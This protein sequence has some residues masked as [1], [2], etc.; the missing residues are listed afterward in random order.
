MSAF[1]AKA[2]ITLCGNPLLQSL[3][4]Q[5]GHRFLRRKC[6]LLPKADIIHSIVSGQRPDC[7][8]VGRGQ[9]L[10]GEKSVL[11]KYLSCCRQRS[12]AKI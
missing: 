11:I 2:D 5:S 6:L 9:F 7:W 4:G 8:N 1:G 12:L 10:Q 3:L